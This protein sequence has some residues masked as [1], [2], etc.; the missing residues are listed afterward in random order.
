MI[1]LSKSY[2]SENAPQGMK[3][4]T[5]LDAEYLINLCYM[6]NRIFH[7]VQ[8]VKEVI[9]PISDLLNLK[10]I[11]SIQILQTLKE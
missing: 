4:N 6:N 11:K 2:L 8:I 5:C 7:R 1:I 3:I 10:E 9:A